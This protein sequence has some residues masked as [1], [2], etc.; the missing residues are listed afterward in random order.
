MTHLAIHRIDRRQLDSPDRGRNES[1]RVTM[2]Q[3]CVIVVAVAIDRPELSGFRLC[4]KPWS[5]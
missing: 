2:I 1:K 3:S 4:F 5:P